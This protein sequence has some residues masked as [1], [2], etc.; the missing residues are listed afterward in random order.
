[1]RARCEKI[2]PHWT[3][4]II[5]RRD[6]Y[7][8]TDYRGKNACFIDWIVKSSFSGDIESAL[9]KAMDETRISPGPRA[10]Q[11]INALQLQHSS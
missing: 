2:G 1:M 6:R 3:I 5:E 4:N 7:K 11:L 9:P 10:R 8:D